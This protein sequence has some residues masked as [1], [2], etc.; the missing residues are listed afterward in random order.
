VLL[1]QA[2]RS[3]LDT[4]A[5]QYASGYHFLLTI[6]TPAGPDNYSK[7]QL[8]TM[9]GIVDFM[10]LMA[11]D[12]DGSWS[13]TAGH[14]ANLY[15]NPSL[16]VS[17][18]FNTD[19]AVKYYISQG[20]PAAK[21]VLGMPIYGR[22]FESTNGLGQAYSGIGGG[23]WENG[24]WDYKVLPKAG[25][26]EYFDA[27]AYASYS[28]DPVTKELITYDNVA[29]VQRKVSYLQS[30]GMGGSMFWEISADRTDSGSLV[31]ASYTSLGSL[32]S[33]QNLLSYPQSQYANIVA[34]LV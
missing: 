15:N 4:Y 1:L 14:Q 6:A 29:M 28:Y 7:L 8:N 12:Y 22:A 32:A 27:V 10:N 13:T 16:P 26:T 21:I 3:A 11:Y 9:G 24:V 20:V 23:S 2:V 5:A 33:S 19:Q 18:P 34:G 31:G 30:Q 17:T 25:A